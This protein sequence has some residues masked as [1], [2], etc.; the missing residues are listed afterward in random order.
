MLN[1]VLAT[2]SCTLE[3]LSSRTLAA[4]VDDCQEVRREQNHLPCLCGLQADVPVA[5]RV[6]VAAK[7]PGHEVHQCLAFSRFS[8]QGEALGAPCPKRRAWDLPW[9][10][11]GVPTVCAV[12]VM[13]A[14]STLQNR[15]TSE[16]ESV[17]DPR[18]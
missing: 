8:L 12:S 16:E 10:P 7:R 6:L 1:R 5:L 9:L 17:A 2:E 11:A 3:A 18:E 13:H 4:R 15:N 14:N